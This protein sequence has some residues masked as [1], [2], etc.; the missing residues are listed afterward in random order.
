MK[1]VR[2]IITGRVQGVFFRAFVEKT[3]NELGVKGQVRNYDNG[4][5]GIV[6][7]GD[8]EQLKAFIKLC[9]QGPPGAEVKKVQVEDEE[10]GPRYKN[11]DIAY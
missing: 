7:Q 4:N 3:A 9:K 6:A 11:F 10:L 2:L 1:Q 5:V 8:E